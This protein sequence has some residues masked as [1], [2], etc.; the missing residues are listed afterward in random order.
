MNEHEAREM[1]NGLTRQRR[2]EVINP[3]LS[4]RLRA[5]RYI[6]DYR[7]QRLPCLC[8]DDQC[9]ELSPLSFR[10][11]LGHPDFLGPMWLKIKEKEDAGDL[12]DKYPR[13]HKGVY[14][15]MSQVETWPNYSMIPRDGLAGFTHILKQT[16]WNS[17]R[18]FVDE[19]LARN[20]WEI[21]PFQYKKRVLCI[22][23]GRRYQEIQ[24]DVLLYLQN[25]EEQLVNH[26]PL[27]ESLESIHRQFV[28]PIR[29]PLGKKKALR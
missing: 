13:I 7:D 10:N 21:S 22:V 29:D 3:V 15:F 11:L 5:N 23:R 28:T 18:V 6:H 16:M 17:H 1:P 2:R 4:L 9:S 14:R 25:Y 26:I 20:F 8:T 24:E 27:G 19:V 12:H